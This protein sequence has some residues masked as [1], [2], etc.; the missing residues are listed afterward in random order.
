MFRNVDVMLILINFDLMLITHD[1]EDRKPCKPVA[2][3]VSQDTSSKAD[4][5]HSGV[6]KSN[7]S[8]RPRVNQETMR[9]AL[10]HYS[11]FPFHLTLL[12]MAAPSE[13]ILMMSWG[14]GLSLVGELWNMLTHCL[15]AH[16]KRINKPE[17][18]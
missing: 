9:Y 11:T 7:T 17:T 4:Q 8:S 18:L 5:A 6:C 1:I 2:C 16:F 15:A 13:G 12:A 10:P 3:A 14:T